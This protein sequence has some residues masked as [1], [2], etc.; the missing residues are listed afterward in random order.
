[1]SLETCRK[2]KLP[3]K[4]DGRDNK[5]IIYLLGVATI[6]IFKHISRFGGLIDNIGTF[7][8]ARPF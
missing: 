5:R 2:D 4:D 8:L 6:L 1:M 3:A 7:H